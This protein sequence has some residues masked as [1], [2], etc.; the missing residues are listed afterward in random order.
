MKPKEDPQVCAF[1]AAVLLLHLHS[2]CSEWE[3]LT[4]NHDIEFVHRMRVASRRF[5]SAFDIFSPCLPKKK[6]TAWARQVSALTTSLSRARD[7]DVQIALLDDFASKLP[8]PQLHPG[9]QRLLLRNRQ[10]REKLQPQVSADLEQIKQSGVLEEMEITL[11]NMLPPAEQDPAPYSP[12]LYLLAYKSINHGMN[13][14]LSYDGLIQEPNRSEELH[15]MRL[16]AKN[17]RYT[18]EIFQK[19]YV[20]QLEKQ[21]QAVKEMQTRLGEIHDADV[22]SRKLEK[23]LV[24]ERERTRKYYGHT[25]PFQLLVPGIH[26]FQENRQQN[27]QQHY[28][29]FL[30]QWEEWK[31]DNLWG[32]LYQTIKLPTIISFPEPE[33]ANTSP[34][35]D[36]LAAL[37]PESP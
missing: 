18:M 3:G 37:P 21:L 6:R 13:K 5:R 7:L 34:S 8:A 11:Q 35:P 9:I 4:H 32:G 33:A 31:H 16:E 19:L 10:K 22:W 30:R 29:D 24:T 17:L 12:G 1:G 36:T 2:M 15:R 26:Y 14:L 20:D 25:R 27:R 28:Q 23:F